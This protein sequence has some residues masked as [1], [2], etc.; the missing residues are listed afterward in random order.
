MN[1]AE[2]ICA[3][4]VAVLAYA[5]VGYPILL[6][7]VAR[8]S[9]ADAPL[10]ATALPTLHISVILSAYNEERHIAERISNL[11]AQDWP[12]DCLDILVG[13]D[14]CTDETVARA[15]EAG[16]SSENVRVF[17]F[18]D[19]R[20]KVAVLKELVSSAERGAAKGQERSH[21]LVFTDAN[22]EFEED[23][24]RKLVRHFK[25]E[26]VGGVC[27]RLVFRDGGDETHENA[28]WRM[29]TWLKQRESGLDSCL[30]ANGAIYAIRDELFWDGIPDNTIID[31]FVIG[32]KV[33]EQGFRV[34][35]DSNAV[36]AEELPVSVSDEW[37][38]RVRIGSGDF[39][40]LSMCRR[41]LGPRM[42]AFSWCFW[43]HKVLRW[44]TP[45][46][47]LVMSLAAAVALLM[48]ASLFAYCV[49]GCVVFFLAASALGRACRGLRSPVV[50]PFRLCDYFATM[51]AAIFVGFL[52]YC[53]GDLKGT[54]KRTAR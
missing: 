24:L 10:E 26:R 46:L 28:Y 18:S 6:A 29:E 1:T 3:L 12:D 22:T 14:G 9:S 50:T 36:G 47:L 27:G 2:T 15:R 8:R 31:D 16:S 32:M 23:A 4:C 48:G 49:L 19:N 5:W 37:H 52:R 42:G 41:S 30:G 45:H 43:S 33:R 44:F 11:L 7:L 35:Y 51:Q 53:R 17:E 21:I 20:G 40:A 34:V 39:Q 25:D 54:W 13:T 38:R